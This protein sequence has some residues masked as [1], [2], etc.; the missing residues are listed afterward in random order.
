VRLPFVPGGGA[1]AQHRCLVFFIADLYHIP[2]I[3]LVAGSFMRR[4][5]EYLVTP[6]QLKCLMLCHIL[7]RGTRD[8]CRVRVTI[9][10]CSN[11]C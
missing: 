6:G 7:C 11:R 1:Q 9:I 2:C 10:W 4:V 5:V 3:R 8:V